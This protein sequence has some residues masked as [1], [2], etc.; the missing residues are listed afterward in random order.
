M[1][2]QVNLTKQQGHG[3]GNMVSRVL[4]SEGTRDMAQN[5]IP[6]LAQHGFTGGEWKV[7]QKTGNNARG[8]ISITAQVTMKYRG[9]IAFIVD[10]ATFYRRTAK[11]NINE[12]LANAYLMA[13]APK[14]LAACEDAL[15][16]LPPDG[17]AAQIIKVAV[18]NALSKG[19][20]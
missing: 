2:T 17:R 20:E 19:A 10:S 5:R 13:A 16:E 4:V 9:R 1:T 11:Q 12:M 8:K 14:L 7:V 6:V 18:A 3:S 15:R